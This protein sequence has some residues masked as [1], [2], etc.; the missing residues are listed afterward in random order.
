MIERGRELV[1][2]D[3]STVATKPQFDSIIMEDGQSDGCLPDPASTNESDGR[4][5]LCEAHNLLN[6]PVTSEAGPRRPRRL[7]A[8]HAGCKYKGLHLLAIQLE[9]VT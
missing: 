4:E 7:F 9:H 3:E 6:Q 2:T 5:A 1:T 8:R